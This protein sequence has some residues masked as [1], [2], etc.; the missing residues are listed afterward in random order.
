MDAVRS[1]PEQ[2][3]WL[4]AFL[5]SRQI[6]LCWLVLTA[7]VVI[8]PERGL[9]VDL[10]LWKNLTGAPCPGCGMTRSGA[11]LFRGRWQRAVSFHPLGLI[12]HPLL[13]GLC[14]MAAFPQAIRQTIAQ[15]LLVWQRGVAWLHALF[16]LAFFAFGLFRWYAVLSGWLVFPT[17]WNELIR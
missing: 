15:R 8:P 3:W 9:G 14:F 17:D 16:W 12:L 1:K 6:R 11:N 10:C 4:S 13:L 7:V 5:A 2:Q